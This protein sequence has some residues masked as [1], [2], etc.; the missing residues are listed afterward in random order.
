MS[1]V[2]DVIVQ[3]IQ[4]LIPK[5]KHY[6]DEVE[7][8]KTNVKRNYMKKRLKKINEQVAQLLVALDRVA[9]KENNNEPTNNS[10]RGTTETSASEEHIG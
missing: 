1:L 8:A 4:D 6:A 2:K 9:P 5:S 10:E 7:A 3:E